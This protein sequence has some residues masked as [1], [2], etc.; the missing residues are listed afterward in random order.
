MTQVNGKAG[1]T[2]SMLRRAYL[3]HT[4]DAFVRTP[5]PCVIN[6]SAIVHASPRLGAGFL[7]YTLE[8]EAAGELL[9][10]AEQRFV[11]VIS[12]SIVIALDARPK[13]GFSPQS[14]KEQ[15]AETTIAASG[16]C[17]LPG[18]FARSIRAVER[19]VMLVI[20]KRYEELVGI[21]APKALAGSE[22]HSAAVPLGGDPDLLV[23]ALLPAA[24]A[25]DLAVNTMEYAPGAALAQVEIH[26]MEHGLLMLEGEGTYR[27]GDERHHVTA[28]DFIWMAPYC[29]QWFVAEGHRPAKY[30]IYKDWNRRPRL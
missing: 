4:P 18:G 22:E 24:A 6:G 7:A 28:G 10:V 23:R 13:A 27:L 30:L 1:E 15:P 8:L 14:L 9:P 11:W 16:Y 12:G 17:Y 19:T 21:A 20:E 29:P 2:R 26:V 5:L 25:Y 3:L